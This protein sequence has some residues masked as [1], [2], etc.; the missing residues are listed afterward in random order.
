MVTRGRDLRSDSQ[1]TH[2]SP[3]RSRTAAPCPLKLRTNPLLKNVKEAE[4]WKRK[5]R[6][7]C[8]Y[9]SPIHTPTKIMYS[10]AFIIYLH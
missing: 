9:F 2:A 6:R 7:V 1:V 8:I 5:Y 4:T 3:G 10:C